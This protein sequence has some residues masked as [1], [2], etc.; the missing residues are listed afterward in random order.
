MKKFLFLLAALCPMLA[1]AQMQKSTFTV[2]GTV[3]SVIDS[4]A[5][6]YLLYQ[7]GANRLLDSATIHKGQFSITGDVIYPAQA[8]V[9]IDKAGAGIAK[10]DT[11]AD[12]LVFFV[13]KGVINLNSTDKIAKAQITGSKINDDNKVLGT[14][15]NVVEKTAEQISADVA[16]APPE[17]K[18]SP[19]FQN[20]IQ[21]RY[22]SL[23]DMA[24][25]TL[26]DFIKTNPN[27][28]LSLMA[29]GSL[30]KNPNANPQE[31]GDMLASL[32]DEL[33]TSEPAIGIKVAL[34]KMKSGAVIGM[35]APDF[36]QNDINGAPVKLSSFKG[37]YV[38]VDFWASWCGPC[39]QEN[40]NVVR[41]Y[42]KYKTKNFTILGVSLDRDKTAWQ[43]A[44][45]NDGLAW[46]QV[47]D[48][49]YWNNA[50]A[51]QYQVTSIPQNF[52]IDP[53]GKVIAKNLRGEELDA[54]LAE[55]LGKI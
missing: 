34:E 3:G 25:T 19:D 2:K 15:M 4:P 42:N 9:V 31:L 52:L 16:A 10:L 1:A 11:S 50:V 23:Q 33:K 8:T 35:P 40:P 12:H 43:N 6:A 38:L 26:K 20:Q 53:Q 5:R 21:A 51:A 49:Q 22:R 13:E 27:S 39:R 24:E 30:A 29:V 48:L 36:T 32:S 14:K 18:N 47:S 7:L 44:I 28:F 45:K 55:L 41:A 46:T 54:K 37:K 17:K